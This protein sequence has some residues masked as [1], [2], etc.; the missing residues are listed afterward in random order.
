[1]DGPDGYG[2]TMICWARDLLL[3]HMT[4]PGPDG[5]SSSEA[6]DSFPWS[7]S[8]YWTGSSAAQLDTEVLL[9]PLYHESN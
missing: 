5:F 8:I 3:T 7:V 6:A 4:S 1:M 2:C 9:S